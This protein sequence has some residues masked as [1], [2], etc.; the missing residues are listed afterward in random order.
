MRVAGIWV[1]LAEE[2]GD[3]AN[4]FVVEKPRAVPFMAAKQSTD[5]IELGSMAA[6]WFKVK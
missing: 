2:M 5:K 6:G 3:T 4:C 1:N